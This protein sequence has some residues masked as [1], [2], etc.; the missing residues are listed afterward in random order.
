MRLLIVRQTDNV[1]LVRAIGEID[2]Q[3]VANLDFALSEI[4]VD[5]DASV[6]VDLWDVTFI[7]STGLGVLLSARRRAQRG[8][9]GFAV[10][11]EPT[12]MPR[13]V[14][15]AAGISEALPV[16]ATRDLARATLHSSMS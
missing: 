5:R 10:I 15:D 13:R 9:G 3:N 8:P 1:C 11:A 4:Q 16:F 14:F 2:I 6:L 12:G 7:D